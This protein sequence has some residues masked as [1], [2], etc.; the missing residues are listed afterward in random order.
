MA[1]HEAWAEQQVAELVRLGVDVEDAQATVAWVLANLPADADPATWI[2][3]AELLM[4][5]ATITPAQIED[6]RT[7]WYARDSVPPKFKRLLDAR[8]DDDAG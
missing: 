3:P 8:G 6:A 7:N 4:G 1:T 2:P 5:D